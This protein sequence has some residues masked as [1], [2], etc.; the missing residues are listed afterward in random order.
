MKRRTIDFHMH[1]YTDEI[2]ERAVSKLE[3]ICGEKALHRGTVA[4]TLACMDQW[5]VEAGVLLPVATKPSQQRKINDWAAGVQRAH[6]RLF[7]MGSVHPESEDIAGELERIQALGLHGIKLHPDYQEF[8]VEEERVF[9]IYEACARLGLPVVLHMGR[10]PLSP[11]TVHGTPEGAAEV[12]ERFP[13]L[14]LIL[15]HVGGMN[16][17]DQVETHLAGKK[18]YLDTAMAEGGVP[19]DQLLRIIRA[20]GAGRI[21]LGSDC[22]WHSTRQETELLERLPLDGEEKELIFH[23]NAERLLG[24]L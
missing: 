17:W 12:A 15:A 13:G 7:C 16:L 24:L 10:D 5:G 3:G 4:E 18:V 11:E 23:G 14:T 19:E 8:F 6:P 20:H 2:A 21:L 1:A 22:P 9:P